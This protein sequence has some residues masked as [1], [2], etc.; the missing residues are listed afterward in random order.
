MI[1]KLPKVF[2]ADHAAR[3]KRPLGTLEAMSRAHYMVKLTDAQRDQLIADAKK[4]L[5]PTQGFVEYG[6][7]G[8]ARATI[9]VLEA[10]REA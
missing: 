8:S 5:D 10:Q 3:R 9:K 4:S 1:Y 6:L 2:Y 7:A